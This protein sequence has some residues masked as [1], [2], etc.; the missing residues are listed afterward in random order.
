MRWWDGAAWT[1]QLAMPVAPGAAE[2]PRLSQFLGGVVLVALLGLVVG[3]IVV[4][5]T[6][7]HFTATVSATVPSTEPATVATTVPSTVP[8]A[9]PATVPPTSAPP[10]PNVPLAQMQLENMGQPPQFLAPA[11]VAG[12]AQASGLPLEFAS[13]IRY[14]FH[15]HLALQLMSG[16]VEVPA[17]LGI[18]PVSGAMSPVHTHDTSGIIH[19]E[20]D[21]FEPFTL[22]QFFTEWGQPLGSNSIGHVRSRPGYT[23]YWF[24]D[25]QRVTDPGSVILLPHAVIVGYEGPSSTAPVPPIYSWPSG[26]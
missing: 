22:G 18:D 20:S 16:R 2:G 13:G 15:V 21:V 10:Q 14:H 12:S 23:I 25:G 7:T 6:D 8:P 9:I 17:N 5:T 11:D 1:S 4:T 19:V 24:V 3:G 26:F